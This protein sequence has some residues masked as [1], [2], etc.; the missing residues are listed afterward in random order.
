M[1]SNADKHPLELSAEEMRTL[2]DQAMRE[3]VPYVTSLPE[4]PAADTDGAAELARSLIEPLPTAGTE[5]ERLLRLLFDACIP[6]SFNTAG[7]GYLAYIPG[8]GLFHSAVADLISN[9]VNRYVGVWAAAPLLAQL[10]AN[11]VRWFSQI[12]GYPESARGFLTSGGSLA[13]FSAVVTARSELLGEGFSDGTIYSSDQVHHSVIK[14]A[15][16]AGFRTANVRQIRSNADFQVD[17]QG[18]QERIVSDRRAG[19]RPF[20]IVGSAGTTN[21]GAVDDLTGLAELAAKENVW[22]HVDGAYGGFFMLTESGREVLRGIE[23]ADSITLD[24]H[25]GLFVPYGTGGLLVREGA[26]LK[27]AHSLSGTYMPPMQEDPDFV[28]FCEYSPELSRDFRGLRVWLPVKMYGISPFI[29]NLEEKLDLAR[30]ASAELG[31]MSDIE[32]IAEPQLSTLAFRY[33]R[34]DLEDVELNQINRQILAGV[35]SRR[36]VYLTATTLRGQFVIRICVLS[37]RTHQGRLDQCL[38]DIREATEEVV[39]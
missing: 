31:Q 3:I 2:V 28:D 22:L 20:L 17:L 9:A 23:L 12:M 16:L 36:N 37:F 6:K 38:K 27:R 33:Y 18:L 32:I 19:D 39:G 34:P 7:P 11:V 24:P 26:A 30:R 35:N 15:R 21:T 25:K 5:Y 14:A 4:Q 29:E 1:N 10:E 13:N 8:G